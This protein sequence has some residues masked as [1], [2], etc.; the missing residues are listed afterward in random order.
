MPTY[1][2]RIIGTKPGRKEKTFEIRQSIHDKPL[3]HHPETGQ[4]IERVLHP[5]QIARGKLTDS[6]LA[7]AGFTKYKKSSDGTY[8]K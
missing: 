4:P 2:Y 8:E 3:T 7:D 5:P 1:V 6:E